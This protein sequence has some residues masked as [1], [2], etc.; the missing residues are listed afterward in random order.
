MTNLLERAISTD[1]ADRAAKIIQDALGIE[2]NEVADYC[3]PRTW[4]S[5]REQ[6]ARIIGDWL[7]AEVRS[8]AWS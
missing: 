8:I 5:D 7:K 3:L 1:D 2:S 4:P 6:R